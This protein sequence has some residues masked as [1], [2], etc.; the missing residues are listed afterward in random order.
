MED[1]HKI[2]YIRHGHNFPVGI[3]PLAMW[4]PSG[5]RIPGPE[6]MIIVH[7]QSDSDVPSF[8]AMDTGKGAH[9]VASEPG[10]RLRTESIWIDESIVR[11]PH[12]PTEREQLE[13]TIYWLKR[14]KTTIEQRK[15][16]LKAQKKD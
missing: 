7:W 10:L 6:A 12:I 16:E 11:V 8:S 2:W 1:V 15:L 5:E 13:Y 9:V 14:L 4:V 3:E